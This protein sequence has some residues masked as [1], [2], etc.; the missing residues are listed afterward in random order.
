[1]PDAQHPCRSDRIAL[2]VTTLGRIDPL[3]RLFDSLDG[4]LEAGDRV[5]V[6]AQDH[7][8]AVRALAAAYSASF[9]VEVITS[10][11]GLSIGRNA[12]VASLPSGED[13]M[14]MFPNDNSWFAEGMISR[15]RLLAPGIGIGGLTVVDEEGPKFILPP[16][17]TPLDR[18]NVWNAIEPGF[19]IRRSV[20]DR[21]GGFDPEL[22][23]GAAT[24]WQAG[25]G[26]DLLL[27]AL[28]RGQAEGFVWGPADTHVGGVGQS[29]GLGAAE[30]RRKIRAYGRG[31]ARILARWHY[32]WWWCAAFAAAGLLVG[33][34]HRSAHRPLD[35]WWSFLGRVEGLL[36]RTVGSS[37]MTAV[38]R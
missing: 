12:G 16:P 25:E 35:G 7:A 9:P 33:V 13:P 18:W 31:T 28:H 17:G 15:I 38:S 21:L 11:R 22:G 27:R 29:A 20:V 8:D 4:Q 30:R 37:S 24:P 36:G 3:T 26:T 34:R 10:P 5:V 19:L 1:M 23:T 14:V 2:V 32:P 6:V